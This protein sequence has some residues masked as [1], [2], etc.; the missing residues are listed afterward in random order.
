MQEDSICGQ[1]EELTT[2]NESFSLQVRIQ[3]AQVISKIPT[4]SHLI[5][6]LEIGTY[7]TNTVKL[8]C[9]CTFYLVHPNTK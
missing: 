7:T 3:C 9:V 2:S 6:M 4:T 1:S 5:T 8:V